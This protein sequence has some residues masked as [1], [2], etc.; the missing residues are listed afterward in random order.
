MIFFND[1]LQ[2]SLDKIIVDNTSQLLVNDIYSTLIDQRISLSSCQYLMECAIL[3]TRNDIIDNLNAQL[4]A[5]MRD[6]VFVSY[7]IDKIIDQE[8]IDNYISEYLNIINLSNLPSHLFKL[9]IDTIIILLHNLSSSTGM[10]NETYLHVVQI[11]QRVIEYEILVDKYA[12]IMIFIS[13]ISLIFFF[14]SDL[15]FDFQRTQFSLRL[16]F[17]MTINKAQNQ[18]FKHVEFYLTKS[19]FIHGQLYIILSW[20]MNDTNLWIIISDTSEACHEEKIKNIVY[21]EIFS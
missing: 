19:I 11:S 2:W 6:E 13:H 7:N 10:C 9:K 18:I 1:I 12:E 20:I 3:A 4:F 15:P 14:I 5:T 8:N 21:S 16:M 17:I